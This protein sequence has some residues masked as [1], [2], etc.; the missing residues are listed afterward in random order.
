MNRNG[1][2][3]NVMLT[4]LKSHNFNSQATKNIIGD[5]MWTSSSINVITG[6][7][8]GTTVTYNGLMGDNVVKVDYTKT[9]DSHDRKFDSS[10]K[11]FLAAAEEGDIYADVLAGFD[12]NS[13][14]FRKVSKA[15][16]D[17]KV[18]T[19]VFD[20]DSLFY[21]FENDRKNVYS[22]IFMPNCMTGYNHTLTSER[23]VIVSE[24]EIHFNIEDPT[25][26]KIF[27]VRY[28]GFGK[29]KTIDVTVLK[30]AA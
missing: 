7:T 25:D 3:F 5:G 8:D 17:S 6:T 19:Y 2:D 24:D 30:E 27:G 21:D 22:I 12:F 28:F 18:N 1:P 9:D 14:C 16:D 15:V 11:T 10:K 20:L 29:A 4:K 13:T 26:P 23:K